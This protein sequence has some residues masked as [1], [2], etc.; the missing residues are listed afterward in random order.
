MSEATVRIEKPAA[1]VAVVTLDRP[2]KRNALSQALVDELIGGLRLLADDDEVR[3]VVLTG[4]PPAFSVGGD[5]HALLGGKP[6]RN[7]SSED[8]FA[9]AIDQMRTNV[10]ASRLLREMPKVTIAAINGACAGGALGL[11]CACDIRYASRDAVFSTAFLTAGRSG[12]YGTH[13]LLPRIVG[14]G[15]ARELLLMA[16]KIDAAEA[17][18]IGLVSAVV[19]SEFLM[20]EVAAAARRIASLP[21]L[22]VPLVKANQNDSASLTFAEMLDIECQ[23][24][25]RTGASDDADEAIQAFLEKRTPVFRGC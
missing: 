12:D 3:V 7:D 4:S 19:G 2:E 8:E 22:A 13:W 5:L 21:P 23:L 24:H 25:I 18:R 6:V 11:A 16:G 9:R 20:T 10:E 17:L 14:A 1:S 15:K